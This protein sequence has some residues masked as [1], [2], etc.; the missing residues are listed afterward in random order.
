MTVAKLVSPW[1]ALK[2][3]DALDE[4]DFFLAAS[5][6]LGWRRIPRSIMQ[7]LGAVDF[8]R[9]GIAETVLTV[10]SSTTLDSITF[11]PEHNGVAVVIASVETEMLTDG[12]V[13]GLYQIIGKLYKDGSPQATDRLIAIDVAAGFKIRQVGTLIDIWS[14]TGGVS[15]TFDVRAEAY[16]PAGATATAFYARGGVFLV[17]YFPAAAIV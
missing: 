13:T 2:E 16:Q 8:R 15:T 9:S 5:K 7:S 1:D 17:A 12:S 6:S 3:G 4:S 10:N 14:V 11:T